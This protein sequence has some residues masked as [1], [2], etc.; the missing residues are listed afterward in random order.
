LNASGIQHADSG[1]PA[2]FLCA[3]AC[4]RRNIGCDEMVEKCLD[5]DHVIDDGIELCLGRRRCVCSFM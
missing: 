3:T 2:K 4:L 1:S 5:A